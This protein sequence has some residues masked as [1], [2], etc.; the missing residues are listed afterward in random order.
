MIRGVI[1]SKDVFVH[2]GCIVRNYGLRSYF[3]CIRALVGGRQTTFLEIVW[4]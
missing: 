3:R 1:T 2:A 4:H